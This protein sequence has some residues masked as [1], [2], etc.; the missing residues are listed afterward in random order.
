MQKAQVQYHQILAKGGIIV[1]NWRRQSQRKGGVSAL[2][3]N[4]IR[5]GKSDQDE[6]NL[7]MVNPRILTLEFGEDLFALLDE[8]KSRNAGDNQKGDR[9]MWKRI[10]PARTSPCFHGRM[11]KMKWRFRMT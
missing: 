11:Q 4:E 5:V 9:R 2:S 7:I 8:I 6:G 10:S 1:S 3:S